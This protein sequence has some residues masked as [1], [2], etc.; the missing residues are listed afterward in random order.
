VTRFVSVYFLRMNITILA[1]YL[2]RHISLAYQLRES[3]NLK[4][5][6]VD[7]DIEDVLKVADAYYLKRDEKKQIF[8]DGTELGRKAKQKTVYRTI[9]R[10]HVVYFIGSEADILRRLSDFLEEKASEEPAEEDQAEVDKAED[11]AKQK[12]SDVTELVKT[13]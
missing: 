6:L 11:L 9:L 13:I 2:R 10:D 5:H 1:K 12:V 8:T 4:K 7:M 3:G